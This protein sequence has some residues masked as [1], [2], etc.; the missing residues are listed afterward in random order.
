MS[1]DS[2]NSDERRAALETAVAAAMKVPPSAPFSVR[3]LVAQV[4]D[5]REPIEPLRTFALRV[6]GMR[7]LLA[8]YNLQQDGEKDNDTPPLDDDPNASCGL[9]ALLARRLIEAGVLELGRASD[10]EKGEEPLGIAF[11][12]SEWNGLVVP[13]VGRPDLPRED[14]ARLDAIVCALNQALLV[15]RQGGW[16]GITQLEAVHAFEDLLRRVTTIRPLP[17]KS[18]GGLAVPM[19]PV[20]D[21]AGEWS[22]RRNFAAAVCSLPVPHA[23]DPQFQCNLDEGLLKVTIH[24]PCAD[25][26]GRIASDPRHGIVEL[27]D[28]QAA[29]RAADYALRLGLLVAGCGFAA[30]RRIQHV[31]VVAVCGDSMAYEENTCLYCTCIGRKELASADLDH[32]HDPLELVQGPLCTIDVAEDGSLRGIENA[33]MPGT[34][35]I[36]PSWRHAPPG[37]RE[38]RLEWRVARTLGATSPAD[39]EIWENA[40]R[41][42]TFKDLADELGDST[43]DNVHVILEHAHAACDPGV[44][45]SAQRTV[46]ALIDGTLDAADHDGIEM[47]LIDGSPVSQA[48]WTLQA[49]APEHRGGSAARRELERQLT[50]I[51]RA[52]TYADIGNVTWRYFPTYLARVIYQRLV[53]SQGETVLLVPKPYHD[54]H[55]A[56]MDVCMAE[57]D[58]E[59]MLLHAD[60][61]ARICPTGGVEMA[62]CANALARCGHHDEAIDTLARHL[63]LA[64]SRDDAGRDYLLLSS[65]AL[66]TGRRTLA[67]AALSAALA[68][69]PF[70]DEI[71]TRMSPDVQGLVSVSRHLDLDQTENVLEEQG[72]MVAP[73]PVILDV[74]AET[75]HASCDEGL[76]PVAGDIA[77]AVASLN[78]DA[79]SRAIATSFRPL[80]T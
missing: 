62:W 42:A 72:I 41:V 46:D 7:A 45:E 51:D 9:E 63:A 44:E 73:D 67:T 52:G 70:V 15:T 75:L 8:R 33:L 28:S 66:V 74:L 20:W 36:D 12:L 17:A 47:L 3:Q 19:T 23:L 64:S 48:L 32:V 26:L 1:G 37:L 24:V 50:E 27:T 25:T 65:I 53:R 6:V 60:A 43:G 16:R 69:L 13:L 59:G 10:G 34:Q 61:L 30:S 39:L 55:L 40:R 35:T 2:H 80:P 38:G 76:F 4:T 68:L 54:A 22:A 71:V 14:R 18:V 11:A 56:L 31:W 57:G 5:T 58:N 77:R 21:D 29:A 78:G 49:V 79:V